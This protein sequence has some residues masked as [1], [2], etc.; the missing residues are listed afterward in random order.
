LA[1]TVGGIPLKVLR[2]CQWTRMCTSNPDI[3]ANTARYAVIAHAFA[4]VL[5]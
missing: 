1:S 3:H 2:T 5:P 4:D